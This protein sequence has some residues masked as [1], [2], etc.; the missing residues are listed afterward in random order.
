M[1]AGP[2]GKQVGPAILDTG[3]FTHGKLIFFGLLENISSYSG[4]IFFKLN[5]FTGP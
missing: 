4:R 2:Y 5:D 1:I 3:I